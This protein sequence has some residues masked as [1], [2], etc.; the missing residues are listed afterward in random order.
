MLKASNAEISQRKSIVDLHVIMFSL[1][2]IH[3]DFETVPQTHIEEWLKHSFIDTHNGTIILD[4]LGNPPKFLSQVGN[5]Q[6]FAQ[7]PK[8][9]KKETDFVEECKPDSTAHFL[10][11]LNNILGSGIIF[12]MMEQIVIL[13]TIKHQFFSLTGLKFHGQ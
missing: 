1:A 7:F 8:H 2:G 10:K 6:L 5:K 3:L 4:S 12:I 11:A 9:N 13:E